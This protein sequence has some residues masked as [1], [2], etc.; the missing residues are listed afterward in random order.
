VTQDPSQLAP[1]SPRYQLSDRAELDMRVR[2][3]VGE[4]RSDN[5]RL[6]DF[7][8]DGLR[9]QM[10]A[11]L[12]VNESV[13]L[14]IED[15]NSPFSLTMGATVQWQRPGSNDTWLIGFRFD[16]QSDWEILGELFLSNILAMDD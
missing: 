13:E 15:L 14:R 12:V 16:R 2:R 1:R 6:L 5:A 9:L 3:S 8:R 4:S 7:S 11:P 10:A